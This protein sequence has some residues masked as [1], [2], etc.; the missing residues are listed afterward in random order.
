M[1]VGDRTSFL[2]GRRHGVLIES[3]AGKPLHCLPALTK[4]RARPTWE[5]LLWTQRH[6]APIS[7]GA[8]AFSRVEARRVVERRP[9]S[10]ERGSAGDDFES[11]A[12]VREPR[13]PRPP[14]GGAEAAAGTSDDG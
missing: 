4:R 6:G 10:R 2:K 14:Q 9:V 1:V 13:R 12:G 8:V 11:G 5:W 3:E 7:Q